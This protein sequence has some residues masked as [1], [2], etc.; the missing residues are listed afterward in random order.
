[1][2]PPEPPKPEPPKPEP[3]DKLVQP[4]PP[5][6]ATVVHH[7]KPPTPPKSP[8]AKPDAGV[9]KPAGDDMGGRL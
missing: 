9:A 3:P 6:P 2:T 7:S 1:V 5:K 8:I 4:A